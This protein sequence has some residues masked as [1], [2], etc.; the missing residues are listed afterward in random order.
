MVWPG[1]ALLHTTHAF[2]LLGDGLRAAF[3][4]RGSR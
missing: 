4:P 2:H 3:D 1:V